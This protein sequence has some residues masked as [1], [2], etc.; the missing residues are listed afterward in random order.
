MSNVCICVCHRNRSY[1]RTWY[2][3]MSYVSSICVCHRDR[4]QCGMGNKTFVYKYVERLVYVYVIGI[5]VSMVWVIR[6]LCNY[7]KC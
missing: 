4:Y 3:N 2:I 5:H 1:H 6:C 7:V